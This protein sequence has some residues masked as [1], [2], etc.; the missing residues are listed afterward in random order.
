MKIACIEGQKV[1]FPRARVRQACTRKC[2][3]V[4]CPRKTQYIYYDTIKC[5]L[6]NTRNY[7]KFCSRRDF[8]AR[9]LSNCVE[10][11][12]RN[13]LSFGFRD[14]L[15]E[16]EISLRNSSS[17]VKAAIWAKIFKI[18]PSKSEIRR[19]KKC[20]GNLTTDRW[21]SVGKVAPKRYFT[22]TRGLIWNQSEP[23]SGRIVLFFTMKP[24]LG[25][26]RRGAGLIIQ[27]LIRNR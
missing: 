6:F 14:K 19:Y 22:G 7:G 26:E 9:I 2:K 16:I 8:N 10:V 11:K 15:F 27:F 18:R 12:A 20:R 13:G 5:F 23:L 1:K 25:L 21:S 3:S 17:P 4:A 24:L